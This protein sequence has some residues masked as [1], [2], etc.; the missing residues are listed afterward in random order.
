MTTNE[1]IDKIEK[2]QI[3]KENIDWYLLQFVVPMIRQKQAEIEALKPYKEKIE[4][5]E[6]AY[7][8]HV[9]KLMGVVKDLIKK[10]E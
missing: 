1:L 9:K 6:Q 5:M 3:N 8:D 7:D 2:I 4:M 10:G